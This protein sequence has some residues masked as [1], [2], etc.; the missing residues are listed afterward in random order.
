MNFILNEDFE[1]MA[2]KKIKICQ[3]GLNW[4]CCLAGSSKTALRIFI[5]SIVLGAKYLSYVRSIETHVRIFLPLNI[6][7]VGSV[8]IMNLLFVPNAT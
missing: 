3:N 5:F 8:L 4:Q 6:S 1:P 7:A 2:V